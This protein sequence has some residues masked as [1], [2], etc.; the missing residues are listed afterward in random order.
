[1]VPVCRAAALAGAFA[2]RHNRP[3][4][5]RSQGLRRIGGIVACARRVMPGTRGNRP[6]RFESVV[7]IPATR[8]SCRS[9]TGARAIGRRCLPPGGCRIIRWPGRVGRQG[10][11]GYRGNHALVRRGSDRAAAG[12]LRPDHDTVRPAGHR[13]RAGAIRPGRGGHGA[14]P[15]PLRHR[16]YRG[17]VPPCAAPGRRRRPAAPAAHARPVAGR[18]ARAHA[19]PRG[20]RPVP[21]PP[22]RPRAT[23]TAIRT[24]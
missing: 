8:R 5:G 13:R 2:G 10:A 12:R 11:R 3:E 23:R 6:A 4:P 20:P 1:M 7:V 14:R 18:A 15:G 16:R 24:W 22:T 17:G 21:A 9:S 19:R